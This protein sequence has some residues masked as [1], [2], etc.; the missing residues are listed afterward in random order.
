MFK[1]TSVERRIDWVKV[2]LLSPTI[3]VN[4]QPNTGLWAWLWRVCMMSRLGDRRE[5]PTGF[6]HDYATTYLATGIVAMGILFYHHVTGSPYTTFSMLL[7]YCVLFAFPKIGRYYWRQAILH[8]LAFVDKHNGYS[9]CGYIATQTQFLYMMLQDWAT[10]EH[11]NI[12]QQKTLV[13]KYP[14]MFRPV[15]YLAYTARIGLSFL[16]L[17]RIVVI[18]LCVLLF[19]WALYYRKIFVINR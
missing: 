12:S 5:A 4:K 6:T 2:E 1:K 3:Y 9:L 14:F 17:V 18:F 10:E 13:S 16:F 8:D 15:G 19:S 7:M 11:V